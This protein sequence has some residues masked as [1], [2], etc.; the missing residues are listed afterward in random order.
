MEALKQDK[1]F[2]LRI[3]SAILESAKSIVAKKPEKYDS[4]NHFIRCAIIKLVR[5]ER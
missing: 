3:N 4:T 5:D 2:P 1:M